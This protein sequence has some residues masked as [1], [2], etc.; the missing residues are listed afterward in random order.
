MSRSR[1]TLEQKPNVKI[2]NFG[3]KLHYWKIEA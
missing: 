3:M 2:D 1:K